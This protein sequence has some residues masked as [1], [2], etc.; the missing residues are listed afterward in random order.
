MTYT[1]TLHRRPIYRTDAG[2]VRLRHVSQQKLILLA[3][4]APERS[5]AS[6]TTRGRVQGALQDAA[7]VLTTGTAHPRGYV[8]INCKQKPAQFGY[9]KT[10]S[11]QSSEK[12]SDTKPKQAGLTRVCSRV[13]APFSS[14]RHSSAMQPCTVPSLR[15]PPCFLI[16]R[17]LAGAVRADCHAYDSAVERTN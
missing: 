10:E 4:R 17:R 6:S 7:T 15:P 3:L 9:F 13:P 12:K 16:S 1:N 14:N 8:L 2:V 11:S 5:A